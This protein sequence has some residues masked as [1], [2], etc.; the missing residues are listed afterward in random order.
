MRLTAEQRATVEAI[1]E[2]RECVIRTVEEALGMID[3][4]LTILDA[5]DPLPP[6]VDGERLMRLEKHLAESCTSTHGLDL[7]WLCSLVRDLSRA[8]HDA[9]QENGYTAGKEAGRREA[10][11]RCRGIALQ[12]NLDRT[13]HSPDREY[14]AAAIAREFGL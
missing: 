8:L 10:A 4:L 6:C 7:H 1:R 14:S 5:S 11:E 9:L 12:G 13:D 2:R 3:P